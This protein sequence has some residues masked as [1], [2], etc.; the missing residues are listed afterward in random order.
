MKKTSLT[1]FELFSLSWISIALFALIIALF[2]I[3]YDLLIIGWIILLLIFIFDS[4]KKQRFVLKPHTQREILVFAFITSIGILLSAFVT[5]TIFGGRDEGSLATNAILLSKNHSLNYSNETINQFFNIYG[6]GKALNFP[7]FFYTQ[8]G[9]LRSQ[10]LPAYPSWLAV[11]H[12][13]FGYN[14]LKFANLLPFI[15]FIFSFF[16]ILQKFSTRKNSPFLGVLSL[17]TLFPITLFYKFTL[18]ETF[19][20]A[21]IWFS[22]HFIIRHLEE[23]SFLTFL[24]TFIPLFI[25]PFLRIESIG[26]GFMLLFML[27]LLDFERMKLPKYKLLFVLCGIVA[28]SSFMINAHFFTETIKNFAN[29][30]PI[31][32][33]KDTTKQKD[34]SLIP[35]DWRNFYM[36]KILFNYNILPFIILGASFIF[37]LFRNKNWKMLSPFIFLSPSLIYLIDANISLDHPWMLRRFVFAIIPIS[38]LY[39]ILLIERTASTKRLPLYIAGILILL[40]LTYALPFAT[41]S[42]NKGLLEK[43]SQLMS[44]FNENDLILVSQKASGDGWSLLSEPTKTILEKNAIYFFNQNDLAKIDASKFENIYLVTSDEELHLYNSLSKTKIRDYALSNTIVSPSK[45]PLSSPGTK[46]IDT[47]GTVFKINKN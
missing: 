24:L 45:D 3:F 14:G 19:F 15:T 2:G 37:A 36:L 25:T 29:I 41:Y 33:L 32:N 6:P 22:I 42:Q 30:S 28:V 4:I 47:K 18:T 16:L 10:F 44:G 40:N 5:P 8:E 38:L 31:E 43:T 46:K 34:F 7:G 39:G 12:S 35:K 9:T 13:L 21:L 27:I 26:F 20:A 17:I 23:K 1:P 11:F